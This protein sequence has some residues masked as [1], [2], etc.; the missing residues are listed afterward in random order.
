MAVIVRAALR[1][2]RQLRSRSSVNEQ[3]VGADDRSRGVD[4]GSGE[5]AGEIC[6]RAYDKGLI[7]E[8]SGP[9]D[10]VVK[11]LAPLTTP[12]TTFR[13]GLNILLDSARDV[14]TKSK[15]AAE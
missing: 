8:T 2:L 6:A 15:L 10:E 7:I 11:V 14:L 3:L 1:W 4:V 12:E 9:N 13:K 5:L